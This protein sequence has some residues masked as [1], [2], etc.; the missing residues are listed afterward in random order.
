MEGIFI[1]GVMLLMLFFLWEEF[2]M[3]RPTPIR[4]KE[5][6]ENKY[7]HT[8]EA[9]KVASKWIQ[10]KLSREEKAEKAAI[11]ETKHIAEL[12]TSFR[13]KLNFELRVVRDLENAI[14]AQKTNKDK[15][16]HGGIPFAN[17]IENVCREQIQ[18]INDIKTQ[19]RHEKNDLIKRILK[20]D[21]EVV[22]TFHKNIGKLDNVEA[23]LREDHAETS[24]EKREIREIDAEERNI[25]DDAHEAEMELR[26]AK[27]LLREIENICKEVIRKNSA[28]VKQVRKQSLSEAE[29]ETF[30]TLYKQVF[31]KKGQSINEILRLLSQVN[32]D[33]VR[34]FTYTEKENKEVEKML[35]A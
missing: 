2:K 15:Q 20:S 34:A 26:A 31:Q 9:L 3:V 11:E 13:N 23:H 19:V 35:A 12:A 17:M 30:V 1:A 16:T 4:Q 6:D 10:E 33:E 25:E 8:R 14:R 24:A 7:Q 28:I 21:K 22:K 27:K 18:I 5:R 29:E 32:A